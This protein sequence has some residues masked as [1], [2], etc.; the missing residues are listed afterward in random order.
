[1]LKTFS[2]HCCLLSKLLIHFSILVNRFN[3]VNNPL[4]IRISYI[5]L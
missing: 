4:L 5:L 1:M 2:L 3:R